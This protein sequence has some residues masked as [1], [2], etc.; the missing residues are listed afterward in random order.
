MEANHTKT[1]HSNSWECNPFTHGFLIFQ[2]IEHMDIRVQI[3]ASYIASPSS[4]NSYKC[5]HTFML[6]NSFRNGSQIHEN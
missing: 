2:L 6:C 4:S 1:S 5:P 3:H